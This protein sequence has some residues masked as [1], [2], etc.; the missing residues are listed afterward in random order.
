MSRPIVSI[1]IP[2]Y[3]AERFIRQALDSIVIQSWSE[4]E[5]IVVD[6]GSTD[7]SAAIV[8][9]FANCGVR[10]VRQANR[11]QSVAANRGFAESIGEYIKFFDADD[12]L[13]PDTISLQMARL[14]GTQ[15]CVAS[16]EWGRFYG[17]DVNSFQLNPEAVWCDKA[18]LDWL[19]TS[20]R[21]AQSMMQCGLWLIPRAILDRS[22]L[23]NE[24]LHL[25]NDT[26]FFTRVLLQAREVRFCAGAR[27]HYRSGVGS[28]MTY[29]RKRDAAESAMES[30]RLTTQHV[31]DAEDSPRM[32][33]ACADCWQIFAFDFY[34]EYPDLANAA[35]QKALSLGG[36]DLE[37]PGGTIPRF[38]ARLL[39]WRSARRVQGFVRTRI[40]GR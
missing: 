1:V 14:A 24:R 33:A 11:S 28:S 27:L 4:K 30:T 6:D 29:L 12:I 23:W 38:V 3:N 25:A 20:L 17:D 36:S 16:A 13:E 32:R 19:S 2:C 26:E 35:H 34:Y 15:D 7:R 5:I 9:E 39:G 31:L 10:L 21:G 8:E 37:F 40:F 18:P 22:G